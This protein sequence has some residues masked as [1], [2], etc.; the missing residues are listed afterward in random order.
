MK[1]RTLRSLRL[2]AALVL[3]SLT[4]HSFAHSDGHEGVTITQVSK[5]PHPDQPDKEIIVQRIELAP[6]AAA[7][8]HAHPGMVTGYV[9]SGRLEFQ[10]KGEPLLQLKAGDTF[11]EPAGSLHMVA[12]NPDDKEKTVLIA[13]VINPKG[14]P[15]AQPLP[16]EKPAS[17]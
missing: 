15:V 6:G 1:L 2:A 16:A 10:V 17:R 9:I 5:R 8:P 12:R 11:F 13:F 14:Q 7:L 4:P 3:A